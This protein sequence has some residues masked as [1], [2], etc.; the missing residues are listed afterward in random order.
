MGKDC[1]VPVGMYHLRP[2]DR[3]I[4][5][6]MSVGFIMNWPPYTFDNIYSIMVWDPINGEYGAL[7]RGNFTVAFSL[8]GEMLTTGNIYI[9]ICAKFCAAIQIIVSCTWVAKDGIQMREY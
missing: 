9:E 6:I 3:I 4:N 7:V 2:R 1:P 5:A 8:N